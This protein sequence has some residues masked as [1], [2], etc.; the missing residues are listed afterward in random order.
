[1]NRIFKVYVKGPKY[2]FTGISFT[3]AWGT[4]ASSVE[5]WT[6]YAWLENR[7]TVVFVDGS[8]DEEPR[9]ISA[10]PWVRSEMRENR[11]FGGSGTH[12]AYSR[13]L[14]L[15]LYSSVCWE[16]RPAERIYWYLFRHR[17]ISRLWVQFENLTV[18]FG[19]FVH[20]KKRTVRGSYYINQ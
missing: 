3:H 18:R 6:V 4:I 10:A 5:F 9:L 14:I 17:T 15:R 13:G 7:W 2:Y 8:D 19:R 1:M 12:F 11:T 16:P 20:Q